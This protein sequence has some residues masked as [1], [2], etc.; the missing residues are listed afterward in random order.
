MSTPG[1]LLTGR[2]PARETLIHGAEYEVV[3]TTRADDV[4]TVQ[5]LRYE[6]FGSEP[7][8]EASMAGV[9]DGRDADRFDEFCD[10]LVI[11]HK[12]SDA[13][14]GCYRIL[15]P[16]GAIAAGGLYLATEFELGA[17]DHIRPETLEM[18]RA[19]VRA[20]HRTGGVL[21]LMWAGLLAYSDLR[22]IR[23]AMGA[24]SV[25][26]QYAGYGRG[27]TVRAVRELV[28]AKHRAQWVVTPRT[29]VEEITA[30]PASRRTFPPLVTGYLRMNAEILGAPSYDPVFDV[31]DFPMIID[32]T[33]FNVRYLERLQQ[34]A[35]SL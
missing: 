18:G 29:A 22:G 7:G 6:V 10:H 21:C 34:A 16:P 35:G 15:P 32:R 27:A 25:P 30:E 24:V 14:V 33:R 17:L 1:T 28:D 12:P 2:T 26:M 31:A 8:F 11:R 4:D 23:Y 19:C 3:L 20:D 9:V 5:R 13:I